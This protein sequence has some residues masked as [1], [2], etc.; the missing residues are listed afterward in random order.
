[1]V[2]KSLEYYKALYRIVK[3]VYSSTV[4]E[5][6]LNSILR[7]TAEAMN[8]KG[9]SLMQ[10]TP[11]RQ[12]LLH[13]AA[14]GLSDWYIRKGP[15]KL[16]PIIAEALKGTPMVVDDVS[17]DTRVQYK[18]QAVKEG[19]ASMLSL[20]LILRD[21]ITGVLRVYTTEPRQFS[22]D[23]IEFLGAIANLG[24]IALENARM[25]ELQEQYYEQRLKER[26][27][28][29]KR[30]KKELEELEQAKKRLL[31]FISTVAHDLKAPLAA[32]QS[33]L[34]VILG[35]Y[36]GEINEKQQQIMERSS[37]RISGLLEL[38]SDL[39][40]LSRIEMGQIGQEMES[41][42]LSKPLEGPLDD[43]RNLAGERNVTL[44]EDIPSELPSV[45]GSF[46]RLQQV[47]TNL[48]TNAIKF[49][50][51]EGTVNIKIADHNGKIM[52]KVQDTGVGIPEQDIPH[53]FEDFYRASNVDPASGTGLGLSIVKRVAN[54]HGGDVCVKSPCPETGKGS[55]FTF[56]LPIEKTQESN[57]EVGEV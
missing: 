23:E 50:P 9:C 6:V 40:D 16:D 55:E 18:V 2:K 15:V 1:M 13:T 54:A 31:T 52:V 29:L 24:A 10:L 14:Y 11:D 21:E 35:G 47:F 51:A 36:A 25:Y 46:S 37:L 57:V 41:I 3:E 53:I 28:Q 7:S 5:D 56:T 27:R 38:I 26:A 19:I 43:A 33:Y 39:L 22:S 32:M 49:T 30:S 48:L 34:G 17:T 12:Q 42:P 44:I 20:P 45:N 4:T 8:V